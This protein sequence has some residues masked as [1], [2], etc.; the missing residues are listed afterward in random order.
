[1]KKQESGKLEVSSPE[2]LISSKADLSYVSVCSSAHLFLASEQQPQLHLSNGSVTIRRVRL[3]SKRL[4]SACCTGIWAQLI[5]NNAMPQRRLL[6]SSSLRFWSSPVLSLNTECVSVS[7]ATPVP[8]KSSQDRSFSLFK[9]FQ[10][11]LIVRPLEECCNTAAVRIL[12]LL[13]ALCYHMRI[14]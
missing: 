13:R 10:L 7:L 5:W 1:M 2:G 4:A 12:E 3:S 14:Y 6:C 8:L 11:W 9:E